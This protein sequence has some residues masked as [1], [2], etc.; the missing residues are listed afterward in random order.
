MLVGVI[1]VA[2]PI[3]AEQKNNPI[4]LVRVTLNQEPLANARCHL[5]R[6]L[7]WG[8]D[9]WT[10]Q[11]GVASLVVEPG[12]YQLDV[13]YEI[14][15]NYKGLGGQRL[16]YSEKIEGLKFNEQRE[17]FVQWTADLNP[18][19]DAG[20]V[21]FNVKLDSAPLK[22]ATC[23]VMQGPTIIKVAVT[24][25]EGLAKITVSNGNYGVKVFFSSFTFTDTVTVVKDD[26]TYVNVN[27]KTQPNPT[28][29]RSPI[30]SGSYGEV[31]V[32]VGF[33]V[34]NAFIG[35]PADLTF[36]REDGLVA[37]A[38]CDSNGYWRGPLGTGKWTLKAEYEVGGLYYFAY[39]E[40]T[41]ESQETEIVTV[42]WQGAPY[43]SIWPENVGFPGWTMSQ[44][45]GFVLIG[46]GGVLLFLQRR[47]NAL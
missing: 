16:L 34:Q 38:H 30:P 8:T 6:G 41:L 7:I 40:F 45:I 1:L 19:P 14:P 25:D 21:L 15:A 43:L 36:T 47:R 9:A 28:P 26:T 23:Y 10:D 32:S 27:W 39:R 12:D 29:T 33:S 31:I 3:G 11:N 37:I 42:F 18:D 13:S 44:F 24:D 4:I 17:V 22:G 46:F 5:T 20:Y 2:L 35:V